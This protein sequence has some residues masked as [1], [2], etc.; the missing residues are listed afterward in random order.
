MCL[1]WAGVNMY[2]NVQ[3]CTCQVKDEFG[4]KHTEDVYGVIV[5][6][7]LLLMSSFAETIKFAILQSTDLQLCVLAPICPTGSGGD[8]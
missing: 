5:F 4:R 3:T 1:E 7:L 6:L 8:N 2:K